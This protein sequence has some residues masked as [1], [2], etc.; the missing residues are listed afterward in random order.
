MIY[1]NKSDK[2]NRAAE[3]SANARHKKKR[4]TGTTCANLRIFLKSCIENTPPTDS[5]NQTHNSPICI[6]GGG[7]ITP[8]LI[9]GYMQ[10]G[11]TE[12][13]VD[14]DTAETYIKDARLDQS[15]TD[16]TVNSEGKV[17]YMVHQSALQ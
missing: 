15:I 11:M 6:E 4:P 7:A 2:Y 10:E 5:A 16:G 13:W 12:V 8:A 14:R 3:M 9:E 1:L 17:K